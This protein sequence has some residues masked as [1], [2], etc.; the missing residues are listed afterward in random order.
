[1]PTMIAVITQEESE[2]KLL[3]PANLTMALPFSGTVLVPQ[4]S[5]KKFVQKT[6]WAK[7]DDA[8]APE[9]DFIQVARHNRGSS[10]VRDHRR[11]T[12]PSKFHGNKKKDKAI[13]SKKK[14][15]QAKLSWLLKA[16][17]DCPETLQLANTL[18]IEYMQGLVNSF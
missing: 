13:K 17:A 14:T 15:G 11:Y 6:L 18:H 9:P 8:P 12:A 16:K 2:Q 4:T 1:M 7:N 3:P 10:S 5:Q